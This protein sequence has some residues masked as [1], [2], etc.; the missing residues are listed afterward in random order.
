MDSP[1]SSHET[2]TDSATCGVQRT[3]WWY[4]YRI[5]SKGNPAIGYTGITSHLNRRI[6]QH[7]RGENPSTAAYT[8]FKVTFTAAFPDKHRAL[9]FEAYLK[10]GS[11]HAFAKKRLW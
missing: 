6:Q 7:N 11:G 4:V 5:Q 10:S 2:D 3:G 9:A 1:D 8:P